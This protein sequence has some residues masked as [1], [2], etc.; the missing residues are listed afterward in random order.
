M[1][2]RD[3]RV[4]GKIKK[5][6]YCRKTSFPKCFFLELLPYANANRQCC[7]FFYWKKLDLWES[8]IKPAVNVWKG[9]TRSFLRPLSSDSVPLSLWHKLLREGAEIT[10]SKQCIPK[11]K[12]IQ[13]QNISFVLKYVTIQSNVKTNGFK[14]TFKDLS[15]MCN[16]C[17]YAERAFNCV[18]K[19]YWIWPFICLR[20]ILNI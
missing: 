19:L 5:K 7:L 20:I 17:L 15:E 12:C 4:E 13:I 18:P 11:S 16:P 2:K 9:E 3:Q 6:S 10:F 1:E 8:N 14:I